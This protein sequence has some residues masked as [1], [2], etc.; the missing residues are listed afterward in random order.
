M[1]IHSQFTG[2]ELH[3]AYHFVQEAD[4]GAV[5]AKLY[6][7]KVSTG[8]LKRR[9]DANNAWQIVSPPGLINPATTKGDLIGF[10]TLAGRIAVGTNDQV[11]T[12]D[13]SNS[14]GVAWKD[15]SGGG[16]TVPDWVTFSPDTIPAIGNVMDDEFTTSA[17]FP[18]GGSAK[19]TWLN[20]GSSAISI[21]NTKLS[22]VT[23]FVNAQNVRGLLQNVPSAPWEF[24]AKIVING[25]ISVSHQIVGLVLYDGTKAKTYG[26][27][28]STTLRTRVN[29]WDTVSSAN[30][31]P[32]TFDTP[33]YSSYVKLA[34]DNTNWIFSTSQDGVNYFPQ[35][36][37]TRNTFLTPT[38]VGLTWYYEQ[39]AGSNYHTVDYFRRTI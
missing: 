32:F 28:Y 20:Q 37:E 11:L 15:A 1:A 27:G 13:S 21:K 22:V 24:A 39:T 3:E 31:Q 25:P 19:W 5:G 6:W 29:N 38:K 12:A 23:P 4:P 14:F 8:A 10:S 18:G 30:S 9:N 7:L 33:Y 2:L 34:D 26:F 17:T 36:T 16:G 35:F